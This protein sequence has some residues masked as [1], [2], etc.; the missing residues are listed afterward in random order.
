VYKAQHQ[1][2][3]GHWLRVAVLTGTRSKH[4]KLSRRYV[5]SWNGKYI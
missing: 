3:D 5:S 1:I 4:I 2:Q